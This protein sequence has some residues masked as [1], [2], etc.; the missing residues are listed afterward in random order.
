MYEQRK[1]R[2]FKLY[3]ET[4]LKTS[5]TPHHHLFIMPLLEF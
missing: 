3:E 1:K 2:F 5:S 4:K